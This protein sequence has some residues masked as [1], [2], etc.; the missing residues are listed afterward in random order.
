M[1][2]K[3]L[4]LTCAG[5]AISILSAQAGTLNS[6]GLLAY[7][8]LDDSAGASTAAD[9]SGNG[10]D[11]TVDSGNSTAPNTFGVPGKVGTAWHSDSDGAAWASM[12][13]DILRLPAGT[14]DELSNLGGGSYSLSGWFRPIDLPASGN[15]HLFSN[16]T[17]PGSVGITITLYTGVHFPPGDPVDSSMQ[18]NQPD[19]Q[20]FTLFPPPN[21]DDLIDT[22][23]WY[24]YCY[25]FDV[26]GDPDPNTG[27]AANYFMR[28]DIAF[29]SGDSD[30]ATAGVSAGNSA[31]R[32]GRFDA[33]GAFDAYWDELTVW[34]RAL[35]ESEV[36]MLFNL[37]A[38]GQ[39]IPAGG[40]TI[41]PHTEVPVAGAAKFGFQTREGENYRLQS[42]TDPVGGTWD[43]TPYRILGD[44]S[45]I[46]LF[47]E[48]GLDPNRIYR[49]EQE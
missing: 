37:G 7:Y 3:T 26:E 24:F 22:N 16:T 27:A 23:F 38:T 31:P 14:G 19:S 41:V 46:N 36:E 9:S 20:L 5:L 21:F 11:A 33:P 40:P 4:I 39:E 48:V 32:I 17:A 42:T 10:Y 25:T 15:S 45:V 8:H 30:V 12:K 34:N 13:A 28:Q 47:D 44:N 1:N 35:S 18:L 2:M 6:T 29:A 43:D 49:A